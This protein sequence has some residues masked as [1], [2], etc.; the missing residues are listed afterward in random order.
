MLS[1]EA[2][3][4]A[5]NA[6]SPTLGKEHHTKQSADRTSPNDVLSRTCK[7]HLLTPVG[8]F[9]TDRRHAGGASAQ[10]NQSARIVF[11][12]TLLMPLPTDTLRF[13]TTPLKVASIV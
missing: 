13:S 5:A 1:H 4:A 10:V 9:F 7:A 8:F 6:R 12:L 11:Q 2:P 3:Q